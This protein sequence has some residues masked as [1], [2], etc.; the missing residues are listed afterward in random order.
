MIWVYAWSAETLDSLGRL[1]EQRR[2]GPWSG[3]AAFGPALLSRG[4]VG[5]IL[6]TGGL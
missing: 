4:L 1:L 5:L 3:R 2:P 6:E